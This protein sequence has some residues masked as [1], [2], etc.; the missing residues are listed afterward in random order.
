MTASLLT[1]AIDARTFPPDVVQAYQAYQRYASDRSLRYNDTASGFKPGQQ[2]WESR[3]Y[4]RFCATCTGHSL[5]A[6]TTACSLS[7]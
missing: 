4:N 5:D 2:R 6:N 1:P 3:L 7:F